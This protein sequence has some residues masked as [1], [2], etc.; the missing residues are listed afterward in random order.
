MR[1]HSAIYHQRIPSMWGSGGEEGS[2]WSR[3]QRCWKKNILTRFVNSL[4][5]QTYLNSL[6][7]FRVMHS[8]EL[9]T[10]LW[11]QINLQWLRSDFHCRWNFSSMWKMIVMSVKEF[12][13][14]PVKQGAPWSVTATLSQPIKLNFRLFHRSLSPLMPWNIRVKGHFP[15]VTQQHLS[16]DH[17][18]NN[19][20][21]PPASLLY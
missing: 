15:Q 13:G 18:S 20:F 14:R 6:N 8:L 9:S 11:G 10:L 7:T 2:D 5:S 1:A 12:N 3:W 21:C 19:N 16:C 4:H 17:K